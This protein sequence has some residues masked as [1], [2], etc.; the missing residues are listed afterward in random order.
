VLVPAWKNHSRYKIDFNLKFSE[1]KVLKRNM[2]E[3][4]RI[5][6]KID[7]RIKF[8]GVVSYGHV[9][10]VEAICLLQLMSSSSREYKISQEGSAHR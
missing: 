6:M 10:F 5:E 1:I 2:W 4:S 3:G 9:K 8:L 7:P